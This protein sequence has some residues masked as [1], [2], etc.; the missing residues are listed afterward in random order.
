MIINLNNFILIIAIIFLL[1]NGSQV[2][3]YNKQ[4]KQP[5]IIV[6]M[7]DDMVNFRNCL[8]KKFNIFSSDY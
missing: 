8:N 4:A 1:N 6:I 3:C 2:Y 5:H 7:A